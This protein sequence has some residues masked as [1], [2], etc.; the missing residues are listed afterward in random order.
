M[1]PVLKALALSLGGESGP[2]QCL[3]RHCR[4]PKMLLVDAQS[5]LQ[6][7]GKDCCLP[8]GVEV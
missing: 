1:S 4:H 3:S 8:G 2:T 6:V 7:R 5:P